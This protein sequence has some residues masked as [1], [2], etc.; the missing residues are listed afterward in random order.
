LIII[1][2]VLQIPGILGGTINYPGGPLSFFMLYG[3]LIV[4]IIIISFAVRGM[5]GLGEETDID[6]E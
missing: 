3:I 6:E 5:S 1:S 4:T 2:L